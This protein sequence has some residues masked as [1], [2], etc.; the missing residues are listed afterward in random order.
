MKEYKHPDFVV[1]CIEIYKTAKGISGKEA[2]KIL[3]ESNALD[4]IDSCYEVLH[5]EGNSAI[6]TQIDEYLANQ[7]VSV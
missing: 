3:F 7:S 1:Y 4:F 5:I 6:V 2:Y